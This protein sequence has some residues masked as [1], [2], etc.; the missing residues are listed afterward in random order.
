VTWG[1]RDTLYV[2]FISLPP[3]FGILAEKSLSRKLKAVL[4]DVKVIQKKASGN[5]ANRRQE[6]GTCFLSG[7]CSLSM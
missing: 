5:K 6:W 4:V 7:T 3:R 2:E 1:T